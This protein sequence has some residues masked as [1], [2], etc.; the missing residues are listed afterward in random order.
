MS[1]ASTNSTNTAN[2][3]LLTDIKCFAETLPDFGK[4]LS[5]KILAGEI[6]KDSD[7]QIAYDYFKEE[8]GLKP[9]TNHDSITLDC[10]TEP[11]D[12][13]KKQ[14]HLAKLDSVEGVNALVANQVLEL[15][16]NLTI[17]YGV[18]GSGKSGYTRLFKKAF[19]SRDKEEINPNIYQEEAIKPIK[20]NFHFSSEATSY[21]IPFPQNKSTI[22]FLQFAVFDKK[23]ALNH[24]DGKN[25]YEFKPAGLQFFSELIESYKKIEKKLVDEI[26]LNNQPKDFASFFDG[27]SIIKLLVRNISASTSSESLKQFLPYTELERT[28]KIFLET[29]KAKLITHHTEKEINK[30]DELK[31]QFTKLQNNIITI[32]KFFTRESI[33]KIG[34]AIE[35]YKLKESISKNA[36]IQSFKS[37]VKYNIDNTHWVEFIEA[38][39]RFATAQ[40]TRYPKEIDT[41]L[42]CQQPLSTEAN[43]LINKYW[44]YLDGEA[45][46]SLKSSTEYID[47]IKTAYQLN[48]DIFSEET[49]CYQWL[50]TH[51]VEK[52]NVLVDEFMQIKALR[53]SIINDLT[54]LD[55]NQREQFQIN[56][57]SL[58]AVLQEFDDKKEE[59]NKTDYKKELA[60]IELEIVL[61]S[62]REKLQSLFSQIENYIGKLRWSKSG[63]N[64]RNKLIT[65]RI[66]LKEKELSKKYFHEDYLSTFQNECERLNGNFGISISHTGSFGS[67][68]RQLNILSHNP[69]KILSEGEQKVISIADFLSEVKHSQI[70]KG[71][72]F[73][74]PVTSLDDERK[75][76]IANR[77]VEESTERQVI[78]FTHDL[79]FVSNIIALC[80]DLQVKFDCHWIEKQNDKPGFIWLKNTPSY[81]KEYKTSKKA[82]EYYLEA[83]K[84]NPEIR[85]EKLKNGFA[86]L[87]TS[88]EALV[89]FDFFNGVVQRF[90]ER[91]SIDSL[92]KVCLDDDIKNEIVDNF[93]QCCRYMEGHSHSDKYIYKKPMIENLLAEIERFDSLKKKIKDS[94]NNK[95]P[96]PA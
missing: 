60:E 71:I 28:R 3:T 93:A 17:I 90:V 19:F 73:D 37:I 49:F 64:T 63:L 94:K 70:N 15:N 67:S 31:V 84:A 40:G 5:S 36:G 33:T 25:E 47:K 81:E 96:K 68:F 38:A 65:N 89:I 32:N 61:L 34:A 20:A 41:C 14:L 83:K 46:K 52:F 78:I 58:Q 35:D 48:L 80:N 27:E 26:D 13:Y 42:F 51:N 45:E 4:Y 66:T 30:L 8:F 87:R 7:Y 59:L 72:V 2:Y 91:V 76:N 44:N 82:N 74:D 43:Q 69:S 24:L 50:T 1:S 86:A 22:E 95:I 12:A 56:T 88:Y 18:N 79:V 23:C 9:K 53:N 75:I 77:L 16:P 62:H 92:D 54:T 55:I 11:I 10:P 39:E 21:C 6:L 57:A 85:E 29:K